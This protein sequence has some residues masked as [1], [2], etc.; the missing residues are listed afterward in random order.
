MLGGLSET[1]TVLRASSKD[2]RGDGGYEESHD[3]E[4]VLVQ[5]DREDTDRDMREDWKISGRFLMRDIGA[6]IKAGDRVVLPESLGFGPD[7]MVAVRGRPEVWK[8]NQ[9]LSGKAIHFEGV[10]SNGVFHEPEP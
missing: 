10:S 2:W 8:L 9:G 7:E 3:I 4:D 6:D 1:I 5:F